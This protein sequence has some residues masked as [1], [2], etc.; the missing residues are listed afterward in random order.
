MLSPLLHSLHRHVG[1]LLATLAVGLLPLGTALADT[2]EVKLPPE[3]ATA[4][5]CATTPPART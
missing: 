4:P 5:G 2:Y 1:T 3:L